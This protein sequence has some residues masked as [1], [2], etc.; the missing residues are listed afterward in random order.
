[1]T[2]L[3]VERVPQLADVVVG[4]ALEEGD[5]RSAVVGQVVKKA[6]ARENAFLVER[7]MLENQLEQVHARLA[8]V[9][10]SEHIVFFFGG[11]GCGVIYWK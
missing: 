8:H 10:R 5:G 7:E 9:R 1:M 2:V 6:R 3:N 11:C 4:V